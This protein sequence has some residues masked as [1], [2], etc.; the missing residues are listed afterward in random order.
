MAPLK[1]VHNTTKALD[2]SDLL[3][4]MLFHWPLY[5]V[6]ILLATGAGYMYLKYAKPDYMAT[7]RLYIRDD[8]KTG[9]SEE[10]DALK[11]LSLFK[12]GKNME[13]EM[14]VLQSPVLLQRVISAGAFN[15]R[16]YDKQPLHTNELYVNP[17]LLIRVLSNNARIGNYTFDVKADKN[18]YNLRA[19]A[20]KKGKAT[21]ISVHAD[22]PFTFGKD[23][24]LLHA[25]T[26]AT[27]ALPDHYRI[28]VDSVIELAA[29]TVEDI[30]TTLVNRDATVI[31]LSYKDPVAQRSADFLNAL[32]D[33]YNEY[34]LS[35][36]NKSGLKTIHFLNTRIDSLKDE[37]GLLEGQE[38]HFKVQRGITDIDASSKLA[39][40][41]VKEADSRLSE[42]NMQVSVL[43]QV[44]DYI[45]M[46]DANYPFAPVGGSVDG[47]LT[48]M[49]NRYEEA[50]R[51]NRKLSLSLQ[52]DNVIMQNATAQVKDARAT[53]RDYISGYKRNAGVVQQQ[54]QEKVNGINN[55]IAQ[56]P[57]YA[58]EYVNIKRQQGVKENL[59]LFLLKKKEEA[60]VSNASTVTDNKIIA[61]AYVPEDPV[62]PKKPLI[63]ISFLVLALVAVSIYI[64]I[65]YFLNPRILNRSEIEEIFDLPVIAEIFQQKEFVRDL[66]LPQKSVLTEQILNLRTNLRFLLADHKG[67][68]T[69]MLTSSISGEGKT[70]LTTHIANSLTVNGK[71]VVMVEMDLRKPKLSSFVN[72]DH[73]TG[74]TNYLLGHASLEEIVRKVPGAENLYIVSSGPIPPNPV[75]LI[76]GQ[77]M[78]HLLQELKSA[79]DYVVIDTSPVGI[80]SDAKSIAPFVDCTLFTIRY[81][82]TLKAKLAQMEEVL[83]ENYF[84]K[85]GLIFNG[86]EQH[87]FYPHY[88]YGKYSYEEQKGRKYSWRALIRKTAK[89]IA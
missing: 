38:E 76:E 8:K 20:G 80:V 9:N 67:S 27:A 51:E 89:R 35:D 3:R 23:T 73:R 6:A 16:Y 11:S 5:L 28:A 74:I 72:M 25:N 55:K 81:N 83:R 56:I 71:K 2:L 42:A 45:N 40:E 69:I 30:N 31:L 17:P 37:L 59:Y 82:Y 46:P 52:P 13:N 77:Q 54:T 10:A 26:T 14:E 87:S 53:I 33:E 21:A 63:Y 15:L 65:K 34:T 41:Q 22:Q 66:S 79:F 29:K 44:E 86:I 78:A 50:L 62:S 24:F 47:T 68:A 12:D 43:D 1:V 32:L 19:K 57:A 70:F 84:K 39:L 64:Y 61:P 18:T 49:I 58:R 60:S 48:A 88:Y 7:A 85:K 75:E 36:K 4:K